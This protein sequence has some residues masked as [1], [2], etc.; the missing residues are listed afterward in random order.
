MDGSAS[1]PLPYGDTCAANV[2]S[3]I[4]YLAGLRLMGNTSGLLAGFIAFLISSNFFCI[5]S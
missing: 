2:F 1:E 3:S 4:S 5:I